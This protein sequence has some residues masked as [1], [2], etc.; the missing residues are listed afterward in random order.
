MNAT[1]IYLGQS[2]ECCMKHSK[3]DFFPPTKT[4]KFQRQ[5]DHGTWKRVFLEPGQ[6]DLFLVNRF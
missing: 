6:Q 2:T 1:I 5:P 4:L 3:L